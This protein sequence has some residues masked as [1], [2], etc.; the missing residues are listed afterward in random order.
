MRF[1][2]LRILWTVTCGIA[3][4]LLIALWARSYSAG[5][6]LPK[7]FTSTQAVKLVSQRGFLGGVVFDPRDAPRRYDIYG[8][9]DYD[10]ASFAEPSWDIRIHPKPDIYAQAMI[11]WWLVV[12]I[13]AVPSF[14]APWI[15]WR[16]TLRTLLVT[17]TLVAV[18]LGL[19]VW[20]R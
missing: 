13:V 14:V 6:I 11:P 16:F 7:Q 10:L 2:K 3:C 4:V 19:V 9:G 17:T 1:R 5:T 12:L 18:V 15:C 8:L 20:L